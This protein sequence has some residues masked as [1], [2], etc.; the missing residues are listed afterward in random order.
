MISKTPIDLNEQFPHLS[1]APIIEAVIDI[2]VVPETKWDETQL[3]DELTKR[4]P[5]YP[6]IETIR[7]SRFQLSAGRPD[8]VVED[9]GCVGL[10]LSSSDNLYVGQFNK[11]AFV[12][13]RLKPYENWSRFR[14]EAV[15]VYYLVKSR[16][17]E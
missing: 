5:G 9:F 1:N 4:L 14:D 17:A 2:R 10:K 7:E 11:A 13:S 15:L 8:P 6:K 3:R 16:S 12:F